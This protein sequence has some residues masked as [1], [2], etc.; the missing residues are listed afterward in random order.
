[1]FMCRSACVCIDTKAKGL[2]PPKISILTLNTDSFSGTW[3][4]RLGLCFQSHGLVP[5]QIK[6]RI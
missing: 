5:L 6:D 2:S 3:G 4:C 1:M